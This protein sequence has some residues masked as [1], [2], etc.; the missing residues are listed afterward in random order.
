MFHFG[1]DCEKKKLSEN[2][3]PDNA[4]DKYQEY[5]QDQYFCFMCE[6]HVMR[7]IINTFTSCEFDM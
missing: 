1:Y 7:N 6:I 4:L 5:Y 3:D 2:I